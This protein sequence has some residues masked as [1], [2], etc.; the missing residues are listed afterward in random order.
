MNI[1]RGLVC[2][3]IIALVLFAGARDARAQA[4]ES[5]WAL[6]VGFGMDVSL[7]GNVNSG[8]IVILQG[9][10][11]AI[12]PQPYGEVYGT[13]LQMKVG[14]GYALNE[15]SELRGIF[16]YQSADADLVRLGD[17]GPSSL[18]VQ[19]SDYQNFGLDLG[20]RRYVPLSNP[21]LRVYGEGTIG[22]AFIDSIDGQFAAPQANIIFDSTDFYDQTAAF[23]WSLNF[24]VL[25]RIA[26][27]VD[28]NGQI[29]LRGSSGL[30]EVDQL[31][32]T[33]LEEIN[34]DSARLTLPI[35]F[36]VRFRF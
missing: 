10:A 34:N 16:T 26:E 33:G 2:T 19:Y 28:V 35:V 24:G 9:Q 13:G 20:Y 1:R 17:I 18:Y 5:P 36:G 21:N 27:Q 23:T 14:I 11:T 6:D 22:A 32:G 15:V 29:G 30:S 4:D 12:L 8:A 7:N 25:F 3:S 31:V